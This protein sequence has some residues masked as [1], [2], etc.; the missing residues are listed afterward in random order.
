MIRTTAAAF[1]IL[2][3]TS[4]FAGDAQ[5]YLVATR[6]PFA[7]GAVRELRQSIANREVTGFRVAFDGF[8][9]TLTA[10]EVARLRASSEVRW[11]EPVIERYAV[12]QSRNTSGQTMPYGVDLVHAPDAWA[13][14]RIDTVNVAVLDTGIDYRHP[15]LAAYY[16]GGYNLFNRDATPLDDGGHGTHVAGTIA[17]ADNNVGVV[18]LAPGIRLW[19]VKV[20][21]GAGA[22]NTGTIIGG[23]DWV[24]EKKAEV[25]GNW[26]INL[27]LGSPN[28][29][30]AEREAVN[31][32]TAAGILIVAASGN[33]S[34][35]TAKAP[36][37]FPAAYPSVVA[38]GAIDET[39]TVA[40]FS[41]QGAELDLVA[42]GVAVLSTVPLN[43]NFVSS[44]T[45]PGRDYHADALDNSAVG[46]IKGEFVFCG[47]GHP[48]QFPPSIRG[49]IAVIKRGEITFAN[50]ASNAYQAGA[51]A[52]VIY[53]DV[54]TQIA[55]W[56]L[57]SDTDPWSWEYEWE[58]PVVG[59]TR[60]DG[61]ALLRENPVQVSVIVDAD[62]YAFYSGTSMASPHVAGAAALLWAF[63]PQA[64]PDEIVG[65]LT[66]TAIDRGTRGVDTAYG[67]GV[68]DVFA[69][70]QRLVPSAFDPQGP[71]TGRPI[72]R[73]GRG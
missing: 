3:S 66:A 43:S 31:R 46:R 32:A 24:I 1:V 68:I 59:M 21:N 40:S 10:S 54:N 42:P 14:R 72:G 19:A 50:K 23:I 63:A 49:R 12:A 17:A 55:T 58:I 51:T 45:T 7:H 33:E 61:E 2:V 62:D 22:G 65:A 64:K 25:G 71:T 39:E 8:A 28:A 29:S 37:I 15:E 48:N 69:A 73:R 60:N 9:A 57:I 35:P 18:G 13:G 5:Q 38:V 44:I 4:L 30:A 26:I 52:V 16:A 53:N 6:R 36:V 56:T 20:L 70:A 41:N 11:I 27:S 34:T 67:A 47:L